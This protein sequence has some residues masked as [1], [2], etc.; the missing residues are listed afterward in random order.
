MIIIYYI[1][2]EFI[3]IVTLLSNETV[4]N[5]QQ[6]KWHDNIFYWDWCIVVCCIYSVYKRQRKVIFCRYKEKKTW[7]ESYQILEKV[8]SMRPLSTFRIYF[9]I[10]RSVVH[11]CVWIVTKNP[12]SV[13]DGQ[14]KLH[15]SRNYRNDS[16]RTLT[17]IK[18]TI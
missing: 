11:V 12:L 8:E 10:N 4:K 17:T 18:I 14:R 9:E 2:Q 13:D 1:L 3:L 7:T 5:T 15:G 6:C 16:L